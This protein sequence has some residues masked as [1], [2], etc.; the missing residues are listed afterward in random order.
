MH[1]GRIW[2]CEAGTL[3]AWYLAT[4]ALGGAATAFDLSSVAQLGGYLMAMGTWTIDAGYGVD[5]LAVWITSNGEVIVYRGTDPSSASTWALVGVWRIGSP[6]G[7]RCMMKYKGDL[8]LITQDGVMPLSG[9]L[10][11]SRVNPRVALTDKIQFAMSEAVSVYG[12]HFGW[13]LIQFPKQNQ[14]Y[15]N[16]PVVEGNS[17]QQYVM[18]MISGS[19]CN[20]TNW[21]ANC[22][23]LYNDNLYFGSNGFVAQAWSGNKDNASAIMADG[24]QAFNYFKTP[25]KNKRATMIRPVFLSNGVPSTYANVSVDYNLNDTTTPLSSTAQNTSAWDTAVWDS[26]VWGGGLTTIQTWQSANSIGK[27]LA[28]RVKVSSNGFVT[29]WVSS[30]VVTETGGIL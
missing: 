11:S 16:V 21:N 12:S 5:D 18:N 15:L 7:R 23:V 30:D 29:R 26:A 2:Y 17:Q 13:Q 14:L 19:W 8:L 24:L 10:Q 3:K 9:A 27:A 4:G 22:W 6:V 25:G 28:P 1:K 20:F